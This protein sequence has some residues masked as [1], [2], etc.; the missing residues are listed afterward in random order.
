[1]KKI[2][3]LLCLPLLLGALTIDK[4]VPLDEGGFWG[5]HYNVPK[6]SFLFV[7]GMATWEGSESKI[8]KASWQALDA[9]IM[10]QL[11]TEVY[12]TTAKRERPRE[13]LGSNAW[14]EN[15]K[16]FVSGHVSGMTAM[17]TPY[18]LEYKE[19]NPWIHLLWALPIYQMVGRVKA[20]A[21]WQSDVLG[22][23]IVGFASGYW[24]H[25]LDY[26]FTLYFVDDNVYFG[27]KA[28]F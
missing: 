6:Y 16:S 19:Q 11:V 28:K 8:G 18:I 5:A 24:A 17:V 9:G 12:K 10:S 13:D 26:P 15:G 20:N 7:I 3:L 1:M 2:F 4:K 25:H 22:G 27:L 23:G 14:G 21:H